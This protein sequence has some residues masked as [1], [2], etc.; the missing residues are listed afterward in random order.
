MSSGCNVC[1]SRIQK[2]SL[3]CNVNCKSPNV[4]YLLECHVCGSQYVGESVQPFNKRMNGHR[5]DLTK[6]TLL[7][8]SQHFVN[9]LYSFPVVLLWNTCACC[10]WRQHLQR[11]SPH[12]LHWPTVDE[13]LDTAALT[14]VSLMLLGRRNAT[15]GGS[16]NNLVSV[17]L[18][19]ISCDKWLEWNVGVW[20]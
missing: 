20:N 11:L 15:T 4:V 8:V 7:P 12:G 9:I 16:G 5:S 17:S 14:S 10:N 2:L 18:F 19:W 6:K 1:N 3:F 13:G